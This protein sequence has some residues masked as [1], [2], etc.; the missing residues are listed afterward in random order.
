LQILCQFGVNALSFKSGNPFRLAALEGLIEGPGRPNK[1]RSA[2]PAT[3]Q[4]QRPRS[5]TASPGTGP[6]RVVRE[7]AFQAAVQPLSVFR[8]DRIDRLGDALHSVAFLLVATVFSGSLRIFRALA[9]PVAARFAA[10]SLLAFPVP[11]PGFSA[12]SSRDRIPPQ[13]T[14]HDDGLQPPCCL[15]SRFFPHAVIL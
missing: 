2:I 9:V 10:P 14:L 15:R 7:A 13:T 3:A 4:G 5:L 6:L 8:F 11:F 12:A 1:Q